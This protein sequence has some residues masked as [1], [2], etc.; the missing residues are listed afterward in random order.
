MKNW[1]TQFLRNRDGFC[2]T[3]APRITSLTQFSTYARIGESLVE[4]V[5]RPATLLQTLR[6][7]PSFTPIRGP[8]LR[9]A[10]LADEVR[11]VWETPD[12]LP[13]Q[14]RYVREWLDGFQH[15][16]QR[17]GRWRGMGR[18]VGYAVLGPRS[19]RNRRSGYRGYV[20]RRMFWIADHDPYTGGGAPC[21]A[22]DPRTARPG[23]PG[24]L[25]ARAWGEAA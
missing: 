4:G 22:I 1:I 16:R 13:P 3:I 5:I 23:I 18:R 11:I 2:S 8:H 14:C 6:S 12:G 24:W 15:F 17:I 19:D 10:D 20:S 25:T 9:A 21:E 7:L